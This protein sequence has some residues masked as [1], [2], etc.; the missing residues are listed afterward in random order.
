[1]LL[2]DVRYCITVHENNLPAQCLPWS[3]YYKKNTLKCLIEMQSEYKGVFSI[4]DGTSQ[5]HEHNFKMI[6]AEHLDQSYAAS[7]N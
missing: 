1:M 6:K 5:L 3:S 7:N 2:N 4:H